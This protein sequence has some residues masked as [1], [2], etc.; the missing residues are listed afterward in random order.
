MPNLGIAWVLNIF[1]RMVTITFESG[2]DPKSNFDIP[3]SI[4]QP[5]ERGRRDYYHYFQLR[6]A[7]QDVFL[8]R[9]DF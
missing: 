5:P 7:E 8:S 3:I 4:Y 2:C 9:Y 1:S 6:K